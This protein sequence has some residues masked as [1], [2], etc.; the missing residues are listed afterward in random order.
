MAD[1]GNVRRCFQY[2]IEQIEHSVLLFS[3]NIDERMG[4]VKA[5]ACLAI[6]SKQHSNQQEKLGWMKLRRA[7]S[8]T[9]I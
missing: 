4:G 8:I 2:W 7:M 3:F 9:T 1:V 5:F 6:H